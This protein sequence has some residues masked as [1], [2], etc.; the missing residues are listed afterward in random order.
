MNSFP[1]VKL[2]CALS[3]LCVLALSASLAGAQ[4]KEWRPVSPQELTAKTPVVE[5]D[6]DAEATFWEIRIDDSS[7][8]DV[9]LRHYVRVKIFTERGREKYSK[10]DIPFSKGMKI[11]DLAARVIKADGTSVEIKKEDIFER[12]IIKA[13]GIKIKAKSFAVPNIEPGVIVEYRYKETINDGGAKGMRLA[14]QRDIPIQNLSYYYKPYDSQNPKYQNYNFTDAKFVKDEKGYWLA[15]RKNVP[16][17]RDEPRMPPEDMVRPWMLLT[18]TR[19]G[20]T[21]ISDF[22]ISYTVKDPSSPLKYWG[23]VSSEN[24]PLVKFM[25]KSSGDIKKAAAEITAGAATPDEKLRKI[26]EFCQTQIRNTTFDTSLTDDDRRKLPQVNSIGD[27]LKRKAGSS[28]YIDMLFGALAS[29]S[30]FE[31]RIAFSGN[32]SEM[33]FQ[34]E[35]TN[36]NLIHPAAIALK[37]GEEYKYFNPGMS[38]LPYGMLV[39]Y[40]EDTWAMLVGEKNF[41]WRQTPITQFGNSLSKRSGN[42]KLLDDGTL[43]GDVRIEYSGHPALTYRMENYDESA[44]KR[45]ENLK[46]EIKGRISTA[47]VSEIKIENL[48][49]S[50]KPLIHQYKIRVPSYAQKTGKRLFIQPGFF[51]YGSDSLFS[52]AARKYDIFFRYPW[53]ESDKIAIELPLGFDLDSADAP[54]PLTDPQKIASLNISM[55]IDKAKPTLRYDRQFHFGGGGNILFPATAYP[56]VKGL[57][58]A[59]QKSETHT[60]T[61]KQK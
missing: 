29:A 4:D 40:E 25:T 11:K 18:G 8:D 31:T 41:L 55:A 26:Y 50:A 53:S 37:V 56:A 7:S 33:F 28:Q 21:S 27:V 51:E 59:F 20:L 1:T 35:M 47:E 52:S 48:T 42:F 57:F 13:G 15:T 3:L 46:D 22:S 23:A 10:F 54:A 14:F 24:V 49:E 17:F 36:E 5:P 45:E 19:I 9:S 43:E 60:I 30:E 2:F 44:N 38:F 32:R 12:E 39:W 16:S 58:D 34:P 61:L 6:A